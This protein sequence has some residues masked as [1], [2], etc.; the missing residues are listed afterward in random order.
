MDHVAAYNYAYLCIC[1]EIKPVV[2]ESCNRLYKL[3]KEIPRRK[4][5]TVIV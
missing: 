1:T 5:L 3:V 2:F 4:L